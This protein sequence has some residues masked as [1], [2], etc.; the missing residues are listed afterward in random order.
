MRCPKCNHIDSKVLDSRPADNSCAIRRRRECLECSYRYTTYERREETP[1]IILKKDGRTEPFDRQKIM[2]GLVTATVR[3]N[4]SIDV[5]QD[6]INNIEAE[7]RDSGVIEIKST[8]LGDIILLKLKDL[9]KVAYVR[10]ASVYQD[11]KD[12]D[13]FSEIL[14]SLQ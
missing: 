7:L 1:I 13:E 9:D 2:R 10:F 11:F 6:I 3:R 14:R 5:L 4:I 8:E 12:L